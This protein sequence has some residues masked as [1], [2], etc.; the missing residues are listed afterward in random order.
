MPPK[1]TSFLDKRQQERPVSPQPLP[2][3][4]VSAKEQGRAVVSARP[5]TTKTTIYIPAQVHE[6][7][8]EIAYTERHKMHDLIMEGLDRVIES[9]GHPERTRAIK[10]S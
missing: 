7:L 3:E 2:A 10:P 8:R 6:R 5:D 1:R 9:R 4:P